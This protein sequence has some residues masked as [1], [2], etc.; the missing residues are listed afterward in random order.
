MFKKCVPKKVRARFLPLQISPRHSNPCFP[1]K[2]ARSPEKAQVLLSAEPLKS[3]ERRAKTLK[4][5]RKTEEKGKTRK[6][7][8]QGLEGQGL[9]T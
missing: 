1:G 5:G 4:I 2:T 9:V 3:L 7:K 8:K 6:S